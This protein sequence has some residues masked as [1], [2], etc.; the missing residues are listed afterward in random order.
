MGAPA[1]ENLNLHHRKKNRMRSNTLFR[2]LAVV[3]CLA[4]ALL[5][6]FTSVTPSPADEARGGYAVASGA[7]WAPPDTA[8]YT[9]LAYAEEQGALACNPSSHSRS[10]EFGQA[11]AVVLAAATTP[12]AHPPRRQK[13]GGLAAVSTVR[14]PAR[15][16]TGDNYLRQPISIMRS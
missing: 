2:S 1:R 14:S 6:F 8:S 9:S 16:T 5:L 10:R 13:S 11:N 15:L 4:A 3:A 7:R 12:T